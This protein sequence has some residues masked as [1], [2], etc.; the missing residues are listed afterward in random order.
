VIGRPKLHREASYQ[1]AR[2]QRAG[3]KTSSA[4]QNELHWHRRGL[5]QRRSAP[6]ARPTGCSGGALWSTLAACAW[7]AQQPPCSPV[8]AARMAT[9][10]CAPPL[11]PPSPQL[12]P[13]LAVAA[14]TSSTTRSRSATLR[15]LPGP[16]LSA[17]SA[18]ARCTRLAPPQPRQRSVA[19]RLTPRAGAWSASLATSARLARR[20]SAG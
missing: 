7:P 20:R 17:D 10:C 1:L 2:Q 6:L 12:L 8:C 11:P 9:H 4:T 18:R 14:S 3:L 5:R 13:S 19:H 15:T 16:G